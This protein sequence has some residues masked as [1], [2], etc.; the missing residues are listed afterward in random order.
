M[1]I[2]EQ[3]HAAG[4]V[5]RVKAILLRPASTWDAIGAE[6]ATV[7]SLYL[8]Y[9]LPLSAIGPVCHAIG[10]IAFG[11][12]GALGLGYRPPLATVVGAAVLNWLF[13]L[14]A[15]FLL[16]LAI[17]AMAPLFGARRDRVQSLKI[18]AYATTAAWVAG[19]FSL[20]P[21][22]SM[23]FVLGAAYSLYLLYLGLPRLMKVQ[24]DKAIMFTAAA[25]ICALIMGFLVGIVT[26]M[27]LGPLMMATGTVPV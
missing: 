24:G 2:A 15:V 7:R 21:P 8:G 14:V 3:P 27:V 25:A 9:V 5:A 23:L 18:V 10:L 12:R 26:N 13:S 11:T 16:A 19:V 17:D 20:Y 6:P 4:L 1:T 22:I